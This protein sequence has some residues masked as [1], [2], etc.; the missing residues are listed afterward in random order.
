MP[1]FQLCSVQD[2]R[3]RRTECSV[4]LR[5]QKRDDMLMKRRQVVD[6][7]SDGEAHTE[8]DGETEVAKPAGEIFLSDMSD[9]ARPTRLGFLRFCS[10]SSFDNDDLLA[11]YS[12]LWVSLSFTMTMFS[13]SAY[14]NDQ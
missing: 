4:E 12:S 14:P 6:E 11:V 13:P 2:M 9:D 10:C 3:R 7:D 5:K 8:T 1:C